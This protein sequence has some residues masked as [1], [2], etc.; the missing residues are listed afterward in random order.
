MGILTPPG[1]QLRFQRREGV[2]DSHNLPLHFERWDGDPVLQNHRLAAA[3]HLP[4]LGVLR[5]ICKECL[6]GQQ[7]EEKLRDEQAVIGIVDPDCEHIPA[8]TANVR[9][10]PY[11]LEVRPDVADEH[12]AHAVLSE[13]PGDRDVF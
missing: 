8:A 3:G 13:V 6:G 11:L 1:F 12:I 7:P 9:R 2:E 4:A 5:V 10:E